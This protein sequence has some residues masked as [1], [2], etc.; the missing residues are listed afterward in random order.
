MIRVMDAADHGKPERNVVQRLIG[1]GI[2]FALFVGLGLFSQDLVSE[3]GIQAIERGRDIVSKVVQVGIWLASALLIIRLL[4]VFFWELVIE[5]AMGGPIPRLVKDVV[6]AVILLIAISGVM[7]FVFGLDITGIWATSGAVGL[8]IGFAL[9]SM[10]LDIA[11]GV[12]VGIDRPYKLGDW[13]QMHMRQRELFIVGRVE[14]INWRTTRLKTTDNNL[15]IIPNSVM[16][17]TVVT[18]FMAPDPTSRLEIYLVLNLS[19]P[20]ERALRVL[21]AAA[22]AVCTGDGRG[23]GLPMDAPKP[24]VRI[25]QVN[26]VGVEYRIRYWVIPADCSPN[27][28]RHIVVS[29][30]LE[31][32]R[33]AGLSLAYPK[34]D[35]YTTP[36]PARALDGSSPADLM[37][38]F[39]RIELFEHLDDDELGLLVEHVI[40][41]RY[42]SGERLIRRGAEGD[43]MFV[44]VEG[45]VYVFADVNGDDSEV[46]V[47]QIV[48]GQFFGEMSLLTGERRSAT[49]TA[50]S[51][52][53]AYEITKDAMKQI[54]GRRPELAETISTIVAERKL[55]N[56]QIGEQMSTQDQIERK[57]SV[58]GQVLDGIRSFFRGVFD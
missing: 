35:V 17:Q 44:L 49:I 7:G 52:A 1:P 22:Q 4:N 29:S 10:I 46:K 42:L 19:V 26:T 53:V 38:L 33:Q 43:S 14:E 56:Q 15:V 41:H 58:A 20:T 48:P 47:A 12:A 28:S 54:L 2:F 34:R 24:K 50:A 36:M 45:L 21:R 3:F 27:K 55:G 39:G 32:L 9:R 30:V 13:I 11:T 23:D 40:P 6:A 51:D 57:T 37:A 18:N 5:R 25:T 8:V 31:H 16:G